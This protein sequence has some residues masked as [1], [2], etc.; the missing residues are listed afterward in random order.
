MWARARGAL[1]NEHRR[2]K[3]GIRRNHYPVEGDATNW[4]SDFETAKARN[5]QSEI[6]PLTVFLN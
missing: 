3:F 2:P 5:T 6:A 4:G 1:G